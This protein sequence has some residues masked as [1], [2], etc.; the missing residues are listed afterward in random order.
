MHTP[1]VNFL[2]KID[3]SHNSDKKSS[4]RKRLILPAFFVFALTLVVVI[5][6]DKSLESEAAGQNKFSLLGSM[7]SLITSGDRTL[8][9][10]HED[11]INILILGIG[12]EGHEGSDLTDTIILA[13][14]NLLGSNSLLF[15]LHGTH[16]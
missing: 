14:I 16:H 11:R 8:V 1:K 10:E 5:N 12:G 4:W 7:R 3:G 2:E 15:C 9:G 13:S 6:R